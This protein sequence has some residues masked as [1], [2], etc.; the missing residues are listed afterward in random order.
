MEHDVLILRSRC[1]KLKH[2]VVS[3][4]SFCCIHTTLTARLQRLKIKDNQVILIIFS[5]K[6]SFEYSVRFIIHSHNLA[7][8]W[9]EQF[10]NI[11]I[12]WHI[13]WKNFQQPHCNENS[14]GEAICLAH[15]ILF[16]EDGEIF[17]AGYHLNIVIQGVVLKNN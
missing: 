8:F 12:F 17:F 11:G 16:D 3:N 13:K 6:Q 5:F 7:C 1:L 10:Q 14:L 4:C 2:P 15:D 9:L